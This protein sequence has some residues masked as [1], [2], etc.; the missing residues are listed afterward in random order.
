MTDKQKKI[1]DLANMQGGT[2]TKQDAVLK[3]KDDYFHNP[4]RYVGMV[5]TRMV[6][7]GMLVRLKPG[8]YSV[9]KKSGTET[10]F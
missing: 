8:V 2:F 4:E 6:N 5:I 9:P 10:L 1:I 7:S 3:F